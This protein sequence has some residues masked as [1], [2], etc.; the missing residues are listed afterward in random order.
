MTSTARAIVEPEGTPPAA[1]TAVTWLLMPLV[2]FDQIE[3]EARAEAAPMADAA[4][5]S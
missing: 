3:A 2:K 1:M 4:P 5:A